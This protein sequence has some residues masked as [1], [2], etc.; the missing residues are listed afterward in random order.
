MKRSQEEEERRRFTRLVNEMA[1]AARIA[2]AKLLE[3]KRAPAMVTWNYPPHIQ[4]HAPIGV[5]AQLNFVSANDSGWMV[6]AA[7][8]EAVPVIP[9]VAMCRAA[10]E[11]SRKPPPPPPTFTLEP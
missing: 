7:M 10:L 4:L 6:I 3:D 1:N 11:L 8:T 9:S 2:T 5:A